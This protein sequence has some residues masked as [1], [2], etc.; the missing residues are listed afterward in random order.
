MKLATEMGV[1]IPSAW[2]TWFKAAL[3]PGILGLLMT[4]ALMYKIFPP[5]IKDTPE[6]G[7]NSPFLNS[8]LFLYS[9]QHLAT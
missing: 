2:V 5:E 7:F 8:F 4:P 1:V 3:V 9:L 6:V